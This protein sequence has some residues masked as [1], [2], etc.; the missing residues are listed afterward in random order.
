MNKIENIQKTI[1]EIRKDINN[2]NPIINS[3]QVF[4][5]KEEVKQMIRLTGTDKAKVIK[6]IQTESLKGNGT[7]KD[8]ARCITQYWDFK[9]RLLAYNDPCKKDCPQCE[10][11]QS[12]NLNIDSKKLCKNFNFRNPKNPLKQ[13]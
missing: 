9:G 8:P 11:E 12:M 13:L 10:C 5:L 4:K 2:L 3:G 6:V 1:S 7:E